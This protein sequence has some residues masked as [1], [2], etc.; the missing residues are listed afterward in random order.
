MRATYSKCQRI[1][2]MTLQ[3][4]FNSASLSLMSLGPYVLGPWRLQVH[5]TTV[6]GTAS[7]AA[8]RKCPW[9]ESFTTWLRVGGWVGLGG[10]WSA[11][12]AWSNSVAMSWPD[13]QQV[14]CVSLSVLRVR[15]LRSNRLNC[16]N[17]VTYTHLENLK[18]L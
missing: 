18:V 8:A 2:Y 16:I 4:S 15:M 13:C 7:G 3:L 5:W 14:M 17:N 9:P 12:S 10:G 6:P 11:I 1:A